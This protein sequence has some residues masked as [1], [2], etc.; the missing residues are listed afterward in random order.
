MKENLQI[1][2]GPPPEQT[3]IM[4]ITAEPLANWCSI[5]DTR[6]EA[7][8]HFRSALTDSRFNRPLYRVVGRR[9][10]RPEFPRGEPRP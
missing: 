1:V 8:Q 6:A 3:L 10:P 4:A 7:E 2:F 5:G 9:R